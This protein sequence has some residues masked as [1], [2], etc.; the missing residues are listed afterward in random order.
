MHFCHVTLTVK[1]MDAS[2]RFYTEV[3]GLPVV[4][5][6]QAAAGMEIAFLGEGET[7]VE[8]ICD[9]NHQ[10]AIVGSAISIGFEVESVPEKLNCLQHC[11][12]T[13]VSDIVQPN[14]N[15]RFFYAAD[16][17]GFRVQF[18]EHM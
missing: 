12:V 3:V 8:L 16:P 15:V 6:Y 4:S 11:G 1:D 7:K 13:I 9:A 2:I 18:L 10:N 5:R 14:P 17:D